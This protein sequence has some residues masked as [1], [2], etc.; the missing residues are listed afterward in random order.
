[1]YVRFTEGRWK[2]RIVTKVAGGV[3]TFGATPP[4]VA[5]YEGPTGRRYVK[6]PAAPEGAAGPHSPESPGVPGAG[7]G[8]EGDSLGNVRRGDWIRTSDLLNP[9]YGDKPQTPS[10]SPLAKSLYRRKRIISMDLL[11]DC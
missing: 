3:V 4:P 2:K 5:L 8:G 7:P 6:G 9:I 10:I 1:M 11:R